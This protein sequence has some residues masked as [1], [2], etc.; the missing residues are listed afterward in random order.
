M[1]VHHG[2]IVEVWSP[3]SSLHGFKGSNSGCMASQ[4]SIYTHGK[5]SILTGPSYQ[6]EI[7]ISEEK[8]YHV[9]ILES[10]IL[11]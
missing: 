4:V 3:H 5:V 7:T 1:S 9:F 6:P 8:I 10:A 11:I 2:L